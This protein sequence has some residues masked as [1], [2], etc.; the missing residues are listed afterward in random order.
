MN[1]SVAF[2][3]FIIL[4]N[5]QLYLFQ[6]F[7]SCPKEIS[8]PLGRCSSFVVPKSYWQSLICIL[9]LW[10]YLFWLY[11]LMETYMKFMTFCAWLLSSSIFLKFIHTVSCIS[12]TLIF[13]LCISIPLY[14]YTTISL[15]IHPL[16]NICVFFY[17]WLLWVVLLWTYVHMYL[18][19]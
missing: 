16:M 14:V 10:M 7:S 13:Y 4:G 9:S 2:S 19:E 12:T 5:C 15:S 8:Y 11:H 1:N 18:Y 6:V 17:L 3:T